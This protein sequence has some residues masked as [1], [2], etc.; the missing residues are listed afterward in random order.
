[1]T[2]AR[3]A[4]EG[5]LRNWVQASQDHARV[6]LL[7]AV[8]LAV[9]CA[10]YVQGHFSVD[11]NS[12]NLISEK[13]PWRRA[14]M[15]LDQLF[16]VLSNTLVVVIESHTSELADE[17][18]RQLVA[19]LS[20]RKDVINDVFALETQPFF[21]RNGL[22]YLEPQRLQA[23]ADDL[24]RAQPF[25][26]ALRAD[27]SLHGL[28]TLL[29]RALERPKDAPQIAAALPKI[30][31]AVAAAREQRFYRLS[32][33]E[34]TAPAAN[35]SGHSEIR[36]IELAPN[37][38]YASVRPAHEVITTVRA[39]VAQLQ[40]TPNHDVTVRLTGSIAMEDEELLSTARGAGL[41]LLGALGA[42]IVL[43]YLTLRSFALVA[44]TLVTVLFGLLVTVTFASLAIGHLNLISLAVGVL[45]IGLG[46]NYALYLC[47]EYREL[48]GH[49]VAQRDAMP[50]AAC[51]VGAF[52][53]VCVATTSAGFLA[54]VPTSFTAIADLGV[55][56]AFGMVAAVVSTLTLLPALLTMW[57]PRA[58]KVQLVLTQEDLLSRLLNWP[59]GHGRVVLTGGALALVVGLLIAPRVIFDPDPLN[60]RDPRSESVATFRRLQSNPEI[61]TMTLSA[62]T[63]NAQAA[64][65]L[66]QKTQALPLVLR[67]M[68]INEFIPQQ[69]PEKLAI[70][71][72][73]AL[74]LGPQFESGGEQ[75]AIVA[76]EDD[77]ESLA[78]LMKQ[79]DRVGQQSGAAGANAA[80]LSS[81]LQRF[82]EQMDAAGGTGSERL[83][84]SLRETLLGTLP[85]RLAALADSLQA[86]PVQ[87]ADLPR[88]LFVRWVSANGT[89]R[90]E[91]WPREV[92]DR[93]ERM[94]QFVDQ[95]RE[96][97]P[98]AVGP[99]LISL[100]SGHAVVAAFRMAFLYS[101]IAISILL[102]LLLRNV[103]DA[104]L[105][106]L[107]L[108]VAMILTLALMVIF[109]M[110]LNFANVIALP[111]IL[112][113]GIDYGV[114]IVQRGRAS[115]V[116]TRIFQSGAAR[117]VL[118]GGLIT[119]ASF[120]NLMWSSHP[121]TASLG[122]VLALG[123]GLALFCALVFLPSII[124]LRQRRRALHAQRPA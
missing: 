37:L 109:D 74:V 85:A 19:A 17:A 47:M 120:G 2:T 101:F 54:F 68:S 107:P 122:L 89:Y 3:Q 83:L 15:E 16:P 77:R 46:I 78:S 22:L 90:V 7:L 31:E 51:L 34:L 62:L 98:T 4:C 118:S 41:A 66:V 11:T 8:A 48:L 87:L 60:L 88:P 113:V 79:L 75:P 106:L 45:Y 58:D 86:E 28:F 71:D 12:E 121:G 99:A 73:L 97:A 38:D 63:P 33:S 110:K 59:A 50:L 80:A 61:P 65:S 36:F 27:L 81:E 91:I 64:Q 6:V 1:M 84:Q 114:Y 102:L 123:L 105:A 67:A 18:Q 57:R 26:G 119:V 103:V 69:Q 115:D 44:A 32:W 76:R 14:V 35:A 43:L 111:L 95:V 82:Q 23:L 49:E 100:E 55:I 53:L 52:M 104:L 108:A 20:T 29:S 9:V 92:L 96:V 5:A 10:I 24:T 25:L 94:Q 42:V 112:G 21:R 72:D 56:T 30:A 39:S 116:G 124:L 93:T 40:L 117:A 13:L 70:I